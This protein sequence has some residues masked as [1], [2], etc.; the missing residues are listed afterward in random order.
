MSK[1]MLVEDDEYISRV[2]ERAFRLSG[3]EIEIAA[4]GEQGW[5]I[6]SE[7]PDLPAVIVVDIALPKISGTELL[8]KIRMDQRF[9]TVPVVVLT[10]SFSEDIE[11]KVLEAGAALYL[12]KIDHEPKS[13][14]A[15]IEALISK[16]Q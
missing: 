15:Q 13:V 6:L 9:S 1:I 5:R 16:S 4:D 11:K 3:H 8:A 10:N 14:V 2:Y 12:L 7:S